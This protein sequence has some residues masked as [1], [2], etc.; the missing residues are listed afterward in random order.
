MAQLVDTLAGVTGLSYSGAKKLLP[1]SCPAKYQ[2]SRTHPSEP[3]DATD[4]GKVV[5]ALTLGTFDQDVT[6]IDYPDYRSKEAR[7]LRDDARA[8]RR[9]P[10]L[11]KKLPDAQA[12]ADAVHADP[13]AAALFSGPG[14]AEQAVTWTD[15]A[16]GVTCKGIFDWLPDC[17][18]MDGVQIVVDLK[19]TRSAHPQVF[20]RDAGTYGYHIQAAAY[21]QAVRALGLADEAV[22]VFVTVE[23]EPPH[24][25]SC[26]TLHPDDVQFGADQWAIALDTYKTCVETGHWPGYADDI[27]EI[28]LPAY[29]RR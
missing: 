3:T 25:V 9:T 17:P 5:H 24:L 28:T 8:G 16:S 21:T 19:T 12:V 22:T 18:T 29:L 11:A 1:P 2:W 15:D 10:I 6:V 27:T 7:T 14:R 26:V 4:F 23:T 20:A 13:V